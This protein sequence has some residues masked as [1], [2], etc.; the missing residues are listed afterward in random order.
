MNAS[1]LMAGIDAYNQKL[2]KVRSV[3]HAYTEVLA[4][5]SDRLSND[6]LEEIIALGALVKARSSQLVPVLTWAQ[7]GALPAQGKPIS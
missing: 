5:L 7:A 1:E 6:E 4:R 2:P 3:A